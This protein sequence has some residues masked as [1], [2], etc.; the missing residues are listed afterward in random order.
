[1]RE[2]QSF[3]RDSHLT[4]RSPLLSCATALTR[5]IGYG[6]SSMDYDTFH[7]LA[8]TLGPTLVEFRGYRV[9]EPFSPLYPAVVFSHF[10]A[11]RE[12][13]WNSD[14]HFYNREGEIPVDGLAALTFLELHGSLFVHVVCQMK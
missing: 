1:M 8:V 12:L 7:L 10:A 2:M 4:T 5:L 9:S 6:D 11:L 13:E 14:L 3:M